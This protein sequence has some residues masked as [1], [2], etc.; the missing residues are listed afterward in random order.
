M[1]EFF[2]ALE[3]RSADQRATD[4]ATALPAQIAHA[5]ANA[6]YYGKVLADID[7][8]TIDTVA[9]LV[10]LPVTRK[11]DL[12]AQQA[13]NPPFGG[14]NATPVRDLLRVFLSPGPIADPEGRG[15]DWWGMGRG[16]FAAGFRK[17]D[18]AHNCFSYHHTPAGMMMEVGAQA[19]GC[20]VYPGGVG[21][22][23][24][25][26]QAMA[27]F[28]ADGYIG[29]PDFLGKILER[30]DEMGVALPSVKKAFV[31]GGALFPSMRDAYQ[32]RGIATLQSYGTA[33]L[34]M[35]AYET[36]ALEGMVVDERVIVE[37]LRPGTGDPVAEGEVGEV[38]VT[39][40]NADYP[41]IRF[42]TG[43]MSA[44]LSGT[45]P[46]GRTNVRIKGWMGRADQR[47]KVK[48]MF[49]DPAQVDRVAKAHAEI[50]KIR[51]EVTLVDNSDVMVVRV[52]ADGTSDGFADAVGD[53]VQRELKLRG[54]IELVAP[55][56]LPN[57][58]K[59]I[60]DQRKYEV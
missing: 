37:I 39:T 28:Q 50:A 44:V 56:S 18:V 21:A 15:R 29:T 8:A 49:V 4:L 59:V 41:L 54:K 35:V 52:E 6:S 19:V 58:G 22:T 33:D 25:Q 45:S 60:D 55:G 17:G 11:S 38:V 48:G 53:T 23:E 34:G 27:Y 3:T 5:K 20:T 1:T 47:T 46:C 32:A 14:L 36:P 7:P 2:D 12:M 9:A 24:Q 10:A 30:A 57:D 43:D 31:G 26:V 40:F 13:E 16:M 42:A 51:V